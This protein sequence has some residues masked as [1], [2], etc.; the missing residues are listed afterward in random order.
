MPDTLQ[1]KDI[2]A[3]P[4][5]KHTNVIYFVFAFITAIFVNW[6][7]FFH[8]FGISLIIF[9]I[10]F[11]LLFEISKFVENK[12]FNINKFYLLL[13]PIFH[14]S[15]VYA[16]RTDEFVRFLSM[17][18]ILILTPLYLILSNS[19][20][21]FKKY[22]GLEFLEL[23]FSSIGIPRNILNFEIKQNSVNK[24]IKILPR[25]IIGM[26]ITLPV[27]VVVLSLLLS[28]D[29][30]F[31]EIIEKFVW[32]ILPDNI[33]TSIIKFIFAL[34]LGVIC[35][36]YVRGFIESK[37]NFVS[38]SE[39]GILD[40][41][42]LDII[43]PAILTY[44][45]N[46]IY[47][48]FIVVQFA[49]LF[50]G[51]AF[52]HAHGVI[53]SEY[54]VNGFWEMIMVTLINYIVLYFVQTRF[55]LKS[56]VSKMVLI[57]SYVFMIFS[58]I[59]MVISANQRLMVYEGGY[60]YTTDRM[61]P[62]LFLIFILI[63]MFLL[64]INLL[65]KQSNKRKFLNVGMFVSVIVYLMG[66]S[67]FSIDAFIVNRNIDKF[68]INR[69]NT[70]VELDLNYILYETGI[71]GQTEFLNSINSK[72]MQNFLETKPLIGESVLGQREWYRDYNKIQCDANCINGVLEEKF[73]ASRE[74]WANKN[75][76]W[77]SWNLQYYL[78]RQAYE[79]EIS[80]QE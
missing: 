39:G 22:S 21:Y 80:Y 49:Y 27:F 55:S 14:F 57:P 6:F 15:I 44:S 42:S 33:F 32:N 5:V 40:K 69:G 66:F 71:E 70:T 64:T 56:L 30:I 61:L 76:G 46:L 43:I 53:F 20:H 9:M 18:S 36:S 72:E 62:H 79:G 78:Y 11:I 7:F 17:S 60:G 74:V 24:G 25:I 41:I 19:P 68:L 26:M 23:I 31:S 12:K 48:V 77:R 13:I 37:A 29:Q 63:T 16:L 38:R 8:K 47:L 10:I 2:V 35:W 50:G 28:G 3:T 52:T 45:L 73:N 65:V 59:V 67:M 34:F 54:A 75:D 1:N 4:L 58:S 51:E